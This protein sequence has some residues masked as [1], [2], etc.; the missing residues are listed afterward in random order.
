MVKNNNPQPS[1]RSALHACTD[2][3]PTDPLGWNSEQNKG[4]DSD[5]TGVTTRGG[6]VAA[7]HLTGMRADKE[8]AAQG[9]IKRPQKLYKGTTTG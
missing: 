5:E 7:V 3:S 8:H 4:S 2:Y 9:S 6:H 1:L